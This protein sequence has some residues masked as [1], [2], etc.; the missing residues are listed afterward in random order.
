MELLDR[1]LQAV[2]K[3]LP[4]QR[5]DDIVAEL[6][7]NLESQ[8]D[9][10]QAEIGRPLTP[11][12]A[13]EWIRSL[14]SPVHMA[15]HYQPQQ[16][17][18][19][20]AIYPIYLYVLRLASM[21]AIIVY[22]IVS[23]IIIMVGSP[24]M[25]AVSDAA[26]RLPGVLIQTAAWVTLVFAGIEFFAVRHPEK[27]PPPITNLYSRWSPADLPPLQPA[28]PGKK[29]RSYAHAVTEVIFGFVFLAWLLL[30]PEHPFLMFGPGVAFLQASPF[31]PAPVW[32]TFYWFVV[33][34]N[35]IQLAWKCMDLLRGTWQ[36]PNRVLH[37]VSKAFG[38]VPVL[39]LVNAPDRIYVLL[40]NPETDL[41]RYG[42]GLDSFNHGV[43]QAFLLVAAIVVLQLLWDIARAIY[44]R[45]R[46]RD[47]QR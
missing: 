34:V 35:A 10:K 29:R 38:L 36:Q 12:E 4:W 26:L 11:A 31:H 17:L 46:E 15:A 6:R 8:L 25:Q 23:T 19:G 30:I 28:A 21:W 22:A 47:L 24:S 33:A 42:Q 39:V 27:C 41:S 40:K 37:I 9:E 16:Y 2:K 18:I 43:H 14:G 7:A 1:Y 5:Q 32:M 13:E 3:H 44:D 20:P 45:L